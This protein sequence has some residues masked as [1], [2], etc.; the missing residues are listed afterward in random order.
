MGTSTDK[1]SSKKTAKSAGKT[2]AKSSK[3]TGSGSINKAQENIVITLGKLKAIGMVQ[4]KKTEVQIFSGNSKTK[5]GYE[6]N[7]GTLRKLGYI[8]YLSGS[9]VKLAEKGIRFVGV[10]DPS[11]ITNESVHND[12][13]EMLVPKAREIFDVLADGKVHNRREVAEHLNYDMTKLSGYEKNISKMKTLGF[14]EYHS[15]TTFALTDR[16]FPLGRPKN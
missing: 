4:P 12:M 7:L 13:K 1:T 11:S 10:V 16:C 9:M 2:S 14:V 6:K 5:A 8:E 15:K 3:G